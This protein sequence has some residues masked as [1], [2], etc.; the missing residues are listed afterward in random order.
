MSLRVAE[1]CSFTSGAMEALHTGACF[2]ASSHVAAPLSSFA[3]AAATS[4]SCAGE[5]GEG[6]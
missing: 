4:L 2:L 1:D 3:C 6:G 5:E